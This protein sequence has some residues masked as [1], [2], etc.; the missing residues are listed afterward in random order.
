M[1]T[2]MTIEQFGAFEAASPA[3][4]RDLLFALGQILATRLRQTTARIVG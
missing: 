1:K 4:A 2:A 3:L